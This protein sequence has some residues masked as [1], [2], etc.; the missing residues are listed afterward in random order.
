M[1]NNAG[2]GITRPQQAN[3]LQTYNGLYYLAGQ[4]PN[5]GVP[6][7]NRPA[8]PV[9]GP[10]PGFAPVM[11]RGVND[12]LL[13]ANVNEPAQGVQ[14]PPGGG[15]PM[16]MQAGGLSLPFDLPTS[17]K[18][19]VFSKTGGDPKLALAVRPQQSI[20]WGLNL[21][22]SIVWLTFGI[23]IA[24]SV[25]SVSFTSRLSHQLPLAAAALCVLGFFVLPAPLNICAFVTFV[26]MSLIVAW[27]HR[28]QPSATR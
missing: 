1:S 5:A 25:R 13:G 14:V 9:N 28:N 18:K 7:P 11:G 15:A 4:Q 16:W 17:G 12:A 23:G 2:D 22:W 6:Q 24:V 3:G 8:E 20:R 21:L 26:V 27:T 10:G 19:L